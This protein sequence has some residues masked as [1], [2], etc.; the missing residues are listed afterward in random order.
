[1]KT[2]MSFEYKTVTPTLQLWSN[3]LF[4]WKIFFTYQF[5]SSYN[6]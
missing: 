4:W 5:L 3:W 6:L 2:C 1:M